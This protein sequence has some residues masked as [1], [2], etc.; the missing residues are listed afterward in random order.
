MNKNW[1]TFNPNPYIFIHVNA[2]ETVVCEMEAFLFRP[3]YVK[4]KGASSPNKDLTDHLR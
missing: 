3:K 2:F 4:N 1:V